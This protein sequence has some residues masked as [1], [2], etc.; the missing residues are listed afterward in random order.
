MAL[1]QSFQRMLY[2]PVGNQHAR[3]ISANDFYDFDFILSIDEGVM[4]ELLQLKPE[5][6]NVK[7]ELLRRYH[8]NQDVIKDPYCGTKADFEKVFRQSQVCLTRFL[9]SIN[10]K[11][12]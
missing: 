1:E 2:I 11:L 3:K 4:E 7:V 10:G 9:E 8:P 5:D 12:S 6:S